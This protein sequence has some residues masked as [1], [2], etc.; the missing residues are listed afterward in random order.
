MPADRAWRWCILRTAR[1]ARLARQ[2]GRPI[3][4]HHLA[5]LLVRRWHQMLHQYDELD[6]KRFF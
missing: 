2:K 6:K 1:D 5:R 4:K 3:A